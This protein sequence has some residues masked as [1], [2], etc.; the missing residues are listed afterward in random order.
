[1]L[2]GSFHYLEATDHRFLQPNR[3]RRVDHT[4]CDHIAPHDA[5]EDVH[6]YGVHV[7]VRVKDLKCLLH[8]WGQG[9]RKEGRNT[10]AVKV[11]D[12][13]DGCGGVEV[14]TM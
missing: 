13:C 6:Q 5:T 9:G 4:L 12:G 14:L 10:L 8:L 1:M 11:C 2:T 3:R 7:L